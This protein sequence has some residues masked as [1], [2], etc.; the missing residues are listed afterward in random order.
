MGTGLSAAGIAVMGLLGILMQY[1]DSSFVFTA[2]IIW[3]IYTYFG[4]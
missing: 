2:H 3:F 4:E 1:M